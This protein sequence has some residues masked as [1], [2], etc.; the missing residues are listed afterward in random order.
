M[1][2]VVGQD[3]TI[4]SRPAAEPHVEELLAEIKRLRRQERRLRERARYWRL[5]FRREQLRTFRPGDVISIEGD[6]TY[7]TV[8]ALDFKRG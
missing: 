8:V 2:F 1:G 7:R 4:K 3:T 6:M 5:K